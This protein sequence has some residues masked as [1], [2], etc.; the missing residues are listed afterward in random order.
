MC[1]CSTLANSDKYVPFVLFTLHVCA[2]SSAKSWGF[3]CFSTGSVSENV[4]FKKKHQK[5]ESLVLFVS[6]FIVRL[7][8]S[9]F[10]KDFCFEVK[11]LIESALV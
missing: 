9:K 2:F 5:V 4:T 10:L 8:G 3:F 1:L 7:K 6:L 11:A